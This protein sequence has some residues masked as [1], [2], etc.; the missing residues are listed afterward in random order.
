M[1][2]NNVFTNDDSLITNIDDENDGWIL[3]EEHTQGH[4]RTHSCCV[5]FGLVRIDVMVTLK[6]L[7]WIFLCNLI[8]VCSTIM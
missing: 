4:E 8:D 7:L 2:N 1:R 6:V 3:C 5:C